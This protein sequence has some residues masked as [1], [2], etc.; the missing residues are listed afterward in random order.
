MHYFVSQR[1]STKFD[2]KTRTAMK[3]Q[4]TQEEYEQAYKRM[5]EIL[6][7]E[8]AKLDNSPTLTEELVRVS[9]IVDAYEKEHYPMDD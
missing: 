8:Y 3:S 1:L 9:D 4:I 6:T 7:D 2:S 5:E